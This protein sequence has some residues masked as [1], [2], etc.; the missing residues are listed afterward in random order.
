MMYSIFKLLINLMKFFIYR[1]QQLKPQACYY[2]FNKCYLQHFERREY[3]TYNGNMIIIEKI[4][5][6]LKKQ[7]NGTV[8]QRF[9]LAILLK[10]SIKETVIPTYVH[11]EMI[12]QIVNLM[13]K[14]VN[15]QIHVLCHV[16]A[17][18][19]LANIIHTPYTLQYLEH[20]PKFTHQVMEQFLK[21]IKDQIQVSVL[22]HILICLSY[23]SK[24]NFANQMEECRFIDRISEFVEYYSVINTGVNRKDY[25]IRK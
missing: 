12:Q 5:K 10:A 22:M 25:L 4:I 3:L 9:C 23:L 18:A 1:Y 14:S 8:T 20:Q 16:F 6:I 13:Q 21:F 11:N 7:E 24:E 17:S 2:Q 19:T 15:T